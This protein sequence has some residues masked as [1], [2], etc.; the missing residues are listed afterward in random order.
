[1]NY[2][3]SIQPEEDL[4]Q[5]YLYGPKNFGPIQAEKYF[6]SFNEAFEKIAKDPYRFTSAEHIRN[7][8]RY[9]IHTVTVR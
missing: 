8:Y 6:N 1:M 4:F 3:F 5:I 2:F 9:I 7:D